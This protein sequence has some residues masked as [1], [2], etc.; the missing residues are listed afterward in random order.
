[1]T[2]LARALGHDF[3]NHGVRDYKRAPE[4]SKQRLAPQLSFASVLRDWRRSEQ[5]RYI[6]VQEFSY[7]IRGD[8]VRMDKRLSTVSTLD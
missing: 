4:R 7:A 5:S 3:Q 8:L 6:P 1:M 2:G